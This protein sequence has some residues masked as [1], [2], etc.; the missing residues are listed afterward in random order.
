MTI[1]MPPL[2]QIEQIEQIEQ[3]AK[4]TPNRL[5]AQACPCVVLYLVQKH[6]RRQLK[7]NLG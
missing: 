2:E 3:S 4:S 6:V 5:I 7:R 1:K